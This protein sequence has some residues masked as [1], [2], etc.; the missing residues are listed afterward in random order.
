MKNNEMIV[1]II[2]S[3]H[4][5]EMM[6]PHEHVHS[7][8][9]AWSHCLHAARGPGLRALGFPAGP[10]V[11]EPGDPCGNPPPYAVPAVGAQLIATDPPRPPG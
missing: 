3:S 1:T 7:Q 4:L 2:A 9:A 10:R 5:L 6:S 11:V 8:A